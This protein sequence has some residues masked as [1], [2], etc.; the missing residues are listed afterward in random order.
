[1]CYNKYNKER[2]DNTMKY[3]V[4]VKHNNKSIPRGYIKEDYYKA[5]MF[6]N[7]MRGKDVEYVRVVDGLGYT[8]YVEVM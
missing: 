1:M 5:V 6:A 8:M 4:I 3:T 2:G 7:S